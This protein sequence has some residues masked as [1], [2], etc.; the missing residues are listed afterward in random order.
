MP[1][2]VMQI[3]IMRMLVSNGLMPMP[4]R[5]RLRNLV[6]MKMPVVLVVDVTVFVFQDFMLVFM[7]M[8]LCQTND[9]RRKTAV[10]SREGSGVAQR[11][12]RWVRT[13]IRERY[14]VSRTA[15]PSKDVRAGRLHP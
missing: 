2:S 15:C 10:C 1:M 4:V 7:L 8:P 3:G 11:R 12:N 5:M 13:L 9:P 6:N 14:A